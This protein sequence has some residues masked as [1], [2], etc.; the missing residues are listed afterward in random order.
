M[1]ILDEVR[2]NS[3][4]GQEVHATGLAV[5]FLNYRRSDLLSRSFLEE[6]RNWR[7]Q[8]SNREGEIPYLTALCQRGISFDKSSPVRLRSISQP[9]I[10]YFTQCVGR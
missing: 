5:Y 2:W 3:V 4:E 9:A 6:M 7:Y 10:S 1:V 8:V